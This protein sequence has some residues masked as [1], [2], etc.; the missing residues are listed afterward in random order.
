MPTDK[1]GVT[2]YLDPGLYEK[3]LELKERSGAKSLSHTVEEILKE[4]FSSALASTLAS[5][6]FLEQQRQLVQQITW[7][8][9]NYRTL[10]ES[11][12]DLQRM[13]LAG[14]NAAQ[15]GSTQINLLS[16][17]FTARQVAQQ[18][19]KQKGESDLMRGRRY[20]RSSDPSQIASN[21]AIEAIKQGLTG[22]QLAN[23]L[24]VH[25]SSLSRKRSHSSFSDWSQQLDP[26]HIGW[27]YNFLVRK[28]YPADLIHLDK[29]DSEIPS[30]DS[31]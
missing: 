29:R 27:Q 31:P 30:Q 21:L 6:L 5:A 7:L 26:D 20:L 24:K 23:R 4:Y 3:L 8:T 16:Q 13:V 18:L 17:E 15:S 19:A 2:T 10:Q 12:T 1:P 25:S 28:F 14:A 11:V 9:E 22:T